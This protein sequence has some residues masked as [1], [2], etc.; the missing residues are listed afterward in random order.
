MSLRIILGIIN[1]NRRIGN[2]LSA[3]Q[4]GKIQ[5]TRLVGVTL[6]AAGKVVNYGAR[7]TQTTI[8]RAPERLD[9]ASKPR[10]G[11]PKTWDSRFEKRVMRIIR[12]HPKIT[13][14]SLRDQLHTYLSHDTL[15]RILDNYYIR[16]WLAKKRLFLS[17]DT[18]KKRLA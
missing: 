18:V 8:H 1:R 17:P 16:K 7:T 9:K 5:D 10:S 13:Y 14:A 4:R 6:E 2:K 15:A 11:R 3:N 12:M